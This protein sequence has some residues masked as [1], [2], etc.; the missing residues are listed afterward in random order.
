M[1]TEQQALL[2]ELK[3]IWEQHPTLRFMQILGNLFDYGHDP[4]YLGDKDLIGKL[5][6]TYGEAVK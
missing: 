3:R 5:R 1:R 4:Y 6:H 2:D